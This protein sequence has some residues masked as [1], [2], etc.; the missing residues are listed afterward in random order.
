[1]HNRF[2]EAVETKFSLVEK[3]FLPENEL[4]SLQY[5]KMG[6]CWAIGNVTKPTK[7]WCFCKFGP[8]KRSQISG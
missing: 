5:S 2:Q 4:Q 1:M 8:R 3:N 7:I 6:Q